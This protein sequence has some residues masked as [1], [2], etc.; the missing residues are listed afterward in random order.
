MSESIHTARW[1]SL[2][3]ETGWDLHLFPSID[4]G[5]THP[6][7]HNIT[8]HHSFYS[9]N[10][11]KPLT[12]H[13]KGFPLIFQPLARLGRI[14]IKKFIPNYRKNQLKK[15][16][17]KIKPDVIHS[18]EFQA[19]GYLVLE[20][21]K[22]LKTEF[23]LWIATNW[24]SDIYLFGRLK[25]HKEKITDILTL[26]DYY[27]CECNRDIELAKKMGLTGKILPIVPNTG[28]FDLKKVTQFRMEGLSSSRKTIILKGYQG[29]SGRALVGLRALEL[30]ADYLKGFTVVLYSVTPEVKIAAELFSDSTKIPVIIMSHSSHED[31]LK[32][33]G[34]ARIYIGLGISDAI[35]TSLLEAIVMGAFPIQSNTSCA[36]EW[37]VDGKSG[38]IVPPEDP[39]LIASAIRKA[40]S[41]DNLVDNA[42]Q[43]NEETAKRNL[44]FFLIREKVIE[45]Y[46]KLVID[47]S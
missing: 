24:G 33:F 27:Q 25:S 5:A 46:T 30:C 15:I 16:I 8:I 41:D 4:Y 37:I 20:I 43:I 45:L 6:D 26:C 36:D 39:D 40:I 22:E 17:R 7:F 38:F 12:V 28:G 19:A 32:I 9:N 2:L 35:S 34:Q 1:I 42:A 3:S 23:P 14:L 13:I 31:I 18:L 21:K 10:Q 29:W 11:Q 47:K 44:D